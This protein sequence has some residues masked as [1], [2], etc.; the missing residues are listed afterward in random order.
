MD[1]P[2]RPAASLIGTVEPLL[3]WAAFPGPLSVWFHH[4]TGLGCPRS[5]VPQ[6]GRPLAAGRVRA[7]RPVPQEANT[8]LCVC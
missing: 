8:G 3:D 4:A 5:F 1:E 2:G 7:L 6:A